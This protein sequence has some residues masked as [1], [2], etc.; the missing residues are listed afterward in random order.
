MHL[1]L[2][3]SLTVKLYYINAFCAGPGG[4]C[5]ITVEEKGTVEYLLYVFVQSN[6]S[7]I[8]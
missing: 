6:S 3:I 1:Y 7:A 2:L 8:Q 5:L 4:Y